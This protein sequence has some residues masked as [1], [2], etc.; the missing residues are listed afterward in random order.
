MK[1]FGLELKFNGFDIWHKGNQGSG[2]GMDSDTVDG[3][4]ANNFA[5]STTGSTDLNTITQS[6]MYRINGGL[7]N[8][9]SGVE[10]RQL[11]VIHGGADTITQIVTDYVSGN[12]YWRSGNPPNVSGSGSWGSW[13]RVWHDGNLNPANFAPSGYGLGTYMSSSAISDA[14]T[15]LLTG[16]YYC[17]GTSNVPSGAGDGNLLVLA[18]SSVWLHQI[19]FEFNGA[20]NGRIFMRKLNNNIWQAWYQ[21][22]RLS[23]L[24]NLMAISGTGTAV[25]NLML[26]TGQTDKGI[27][28]GNWH[29]SNYWGIG[30]GSSGAQVKI[31]ATDING[32][33]VS[34]DLALIL[35]SSNKVVATTDQIP[36]SLPANGGTASA[37]NFSDT[38]SSN[39]SGFDYNGMTIHLK[40]NS[41]DGLSDGGT[42][43]GVLHITQWGDI[44]GGHS[45]EI[46]LT[47][48]VNLWYR[49]WNGT[50]CGAWTKLAKVSD[51]PTKLSQLQND[52]GAGGGVKIATANT[53]PSSPSPGDFWY[54]V[55]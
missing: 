8:A 44:S 16:F 26:N 46:G 15:A 38:R 23:D 48:N 7:L 2:S 42:Y 39:S 9:P 29:T 4:H 13:R 31:G 32:N 5:Y 19:F 30:C 53:A 41:A 33:F 1:L 28:N 12:M 27:Y 51:I 45:H 47:D 43:H 18:Y 20:N 24:A 3:I 54:Q 17:N 21:I 37:I 6:G 14:N 34:G 52:I 10:W 49:D 55:L 50:S 11:L 25:P 36:S 40:L 22:A 35:G